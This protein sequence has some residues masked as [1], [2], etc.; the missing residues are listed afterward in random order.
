VTTRLGERL[1]SASSAKGNQQQR[2]RT[3]VLT[4]AKSIVASTK[5]F[6][7]RVHL[8]AINVVAKFLARKL[9]RERPDPLDSVE[10]L[11]AAVALT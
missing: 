2:S 10:K 5:S 11:A 8:P 6:L 3:V 7:L 9:S 4:D 1:L